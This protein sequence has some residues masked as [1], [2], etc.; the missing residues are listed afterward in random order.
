MQNELVI[1]ITSFTHSNNIRCNPLQEMDAN[2]LINDLVNIFRLD[3]SQKYLWQGVEA[4]AMSYSEDATVWMSLLLEQLDEFQEQIYLVV[5]DDE[6][7]P[8][9]VLNC[10]KEDLPR[11]LSSQQFFEFFLFDQT[12]KCILFDTHANEFVKIYQ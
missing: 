4:A 9:P 5:T 2:R 11:I 6:F 7:Y 1:A 8:W 3:L 12:M 10:F